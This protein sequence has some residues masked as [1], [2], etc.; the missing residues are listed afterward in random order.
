MGTYV[1]LPSTTPRETTA[2][3]FSS[4]MTL[5]PCFPNATAAAQP[6][7]PAPTI[8]MSASWWTRRRISRS[9]WVVVEVVVDTVVEEDKEDEEE[10][11]GE[12]GG[13]SRV[14]GIVAMVE[15]RVVASSIECRLVSWLVKSSAHK[16]SS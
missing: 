11:D 7:M 2:R 15:G 4:R 8:T 12:E 6:T 13:E 1:I 5:R 10:E 9:S 16:S 3:L 14:S